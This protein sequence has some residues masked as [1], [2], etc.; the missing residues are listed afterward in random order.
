[1]QLFPT[2]R[3]IRCFPFC[4]FYSAYNLNFI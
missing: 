3:A 4:F 2:L 1:L